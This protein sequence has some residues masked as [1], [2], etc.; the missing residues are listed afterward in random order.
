MAED[1]SSHNN[2][3]TEKNKKITRDAI[4][5]LGKQSKVFAK[6]FQAL[7]NTQHRHQDAKAR[8]FTPKSRVIYFRVIRR[9]EA[10]CREL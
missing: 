9:W 10:V 3:S 7:L 5:I 6:P 1:D 4:I 8:H 2:K